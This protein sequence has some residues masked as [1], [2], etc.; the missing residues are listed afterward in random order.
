M[1][2]NYISLIYVEHYN[3]FGVKTI[4]FFKEK[5]MSSNY[6]YIISNEQCLYKFCDT[7]CRNR[8]PDMLTSG[9]FRAV[10]GHHS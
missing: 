2:T 6:D 5:S 3:H 7:F 1:K 8:K 10:H 4:I 9:G